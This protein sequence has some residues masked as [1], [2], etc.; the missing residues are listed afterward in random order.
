MPLAEKRTGGTCRPGD[1]GKV[2]HVRSRDTCPQLQKAG[3]SGGG[4]VVYFQKMLTFPHKMVGFE[5]ESKQPKYD[6]N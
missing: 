3:L 2:G 4:Q 5:K 1:C 6:N